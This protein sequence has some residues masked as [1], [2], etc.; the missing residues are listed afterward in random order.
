M[1]GHHIL[2]KCACNSQGQLPIKLG[3]QKWALVYNKVEKSTAAAKGTQQQRN[4]QLKLKPKYQGTLPNAQH[5]RSH[6]CYGTFQNRKPTKEACLHGQE[7]FPAG[8]NYSIHFCTAEEN[9][10]QAVHRWPHLT[11]KTEGVNFHNVTRFKKIK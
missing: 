6:D 2:R 9:V 8:A 3:L 4:A 10:P 11:G 5:T 7:E 1:H